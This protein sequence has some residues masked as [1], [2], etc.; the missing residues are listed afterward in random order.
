MPKQ[1]RDDSKVVFVRLPIETVHML[2]DWRAQQPGLSPTKTDVMRR[3]LEEFLER[4]PVT[5][6]R[7]RSPQRKTASERAA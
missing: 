4:N 2:D 5:R 1:V 6:S 7:A 3:A